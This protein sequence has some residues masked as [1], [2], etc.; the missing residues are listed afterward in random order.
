MVFKRDKILS[1][2]IFFL[3]YESVYFHGALATYLDKLFEDQLL[4]AGRN[5]F[6]NI[7]NCDEHRQNW[8]NIIDYEDDDEIEY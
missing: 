4:K 7:R 2:L 6:R 5:T 3:L 8:G 1:K